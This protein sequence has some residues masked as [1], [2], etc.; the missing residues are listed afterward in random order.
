MI[1]K[2]KKLKYKI[3][4]RNIS[5][6]NIS[7]GIQQQ[8]RRDKMKGKA[9]VFDLDGTLLDTLEDLKEACNY[10][11][12][13]YGYNPISIE[14]TRAFIGNGIRRLIE[15]ALKGQMES[16]EL[17]FEAFKSYYFENC[18]V[19]TKPYEKIDE[20]LSYYKKHRIKMAVLS[21]KAQEAVEYLCRIHFP[22]CFECVVG[23]RSDLEKKPSAMGLEL[24]SKKLSVS[25]RDIIYIGDSEVDVQLVKNSGCQGIFVDYGF[26]SEDAL[27]QVG[28]QI[29]CK[30]PLEIIKVWEG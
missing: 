9:V 25:M 13:R 11:L 23:E 26:R 18:S 5:F 21:N 19:Y 24:I 4:E 15:R 17:V 20:L 8:L 22:G 16:E 14:E 28:A 1:W 27:R 29:I 6:L 2:L 12:C 30:S 7:R 3:Y 10:A